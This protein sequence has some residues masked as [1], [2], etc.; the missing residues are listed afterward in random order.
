MSTHI[1]SDLFGQ[2]FK[3]LKAHLSLSTHRTKKSVRV[4]TALVTV[5]GGEH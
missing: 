5:M 2:L 1:P 4:A 3:P